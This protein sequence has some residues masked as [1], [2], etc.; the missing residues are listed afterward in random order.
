M[1]ARIS[2]A[3]LVRMAKGGAE[4]EVTEYH[5]DVQ[6]VRRR[7]HSDL[8]GPDGANR[9]RIIFEPTPASPI[10][11][12]SPITVQ[13][14]TGPP[15]RSVLHGRGFK[16]T[17]PMPEDYLIPAMHMVFACEEKDKP[18]LMTT[19]GVPHSVEFG[20]EPE[21]LNGFANFFNRHAGADSTQPDRMAELPDYDIW[22]VGVAFGG[23]Q[24]YKLAME[25]PESKGI[26]PVQIA[27]ACDI[28]C[29]TRHLHDAQPGDILEWKP[30]D[31]HLR[32][33]DHTPKFAPPILVKHVPRAG[34]DGGGGGGGG[35]GRLRREVDYL[36]D[37]LARCQ[38]D[39]ANARTVADTLQSALAEIAARTMPE[40]ITPRALGTLRGVAPEFAPSVMYHLHGGDRPDGFFN[41]YHHGG[42]HDAD[43]NVVDYDIRDLA[44]VAHGRGEGNEVLRRIRAGIAA[45][46][47]QRAA[48]NRAT[49]RA[50]EPFYGNDL[51]SYVTHVWDWGRHDHEQLVAADQRYQRLHQDFLRADDAL[52][53]LATDYNR[54]HGD[55]RMARDAAAAQQQVSANL[56][57]R[58]A[59]LVEDAT[60]QLAKANA[61]T[62]ERDRAADRVAELQAELERVQEDA[63]ARGPGTRGDDD[64]E[65]ADGGAAAAAAA[66]ADDTSSDLALDLE[67]D[68]Y[69]AQ[70]QLDAAK[71]S[72]RGAAAAAK[73]AAE[74]AAN[75]LIESGARRVREVQ[76]KV[77]EAKAANDKRLEEIVGLTREIERLQSAAAAAVAGRPGAAPEDTRIAE[78]KA[79]ITALDTEIATHTANIEKLT[80]ASAEAETAAATLKAK[81]KQASDEVKAKNDAIAVLEEK[82][83]TAA[84]KAAEQQ[85]TINK[86]STQISDALGRRAAAAAAAAADGPDGPDGPVL[87]RLQKT[88]K[89]HTNIAPDAFIRA[90]EDI[91]REVISAQIADAEQQVQKATADLRKELTATAA[92]ATEEANE[93]RKKLI[94]AKEAADAELLAKTEELTKI[95]TDHAAEKR[96]VGAEIAALI[97]AIEADTEAG[98]FVELDALYT[99]IRRDAR[100]HERG[101]AVVK[102]KSRWHLGGDDG[103]GAAD[104]GTGV[105]TTPPYI[106][107]LMHVYQLCRLQEPASLK[108]RPRRVELDGNHKIPA[109]DVNHVLHS[110]YTYF[111]PI[112]ANL[113]NRPRPVT[114]LSAANTTALGGPGDCYLSP[115]EQT[116]FAYDTV[117]SI[118][119]LASFFMR[120]YAAGGGADTS[121]QDD[122]QEVPILMRQAIEDALTCHERSSSTRST[123]TLFEGNGK[124][125]V[126]ALFL[127]PVAKVGPEFLG[128]STQPRNNRMLD[129]ITNATSAGSIMAQLATYK[130][131]KQRFHNFCKNDVLPPRD[132]TENV[133]RFIGGRFSL[134]DAARLDNRLELRILLP[135]DTPALE[136]INAETDAD[137]AENEARM[138]AFL[139]VADQAMSDAIFD[140]LHLVGIAQVD[141]Y[142]HTTGARPVVPKPTDVM[143]TKWLGTWN[144]YVAEQRATDTANADMLHVSYDAKTRLFRWTNLTHTI[145][146]NSYSADLNFTGDNAFYRGFGDDGGYGASESARRDPASEE[147]ARFRSY[148][149]ATGVEKDSDFPTNMARNKVVRRSYVGYAMKRD[150][151]LAGHETEQ[152]GLLFAALDYS[153]ERTAQG[154]DEQ[155]FLSRTQNLS[156]GA[157]EYAAQAFTAMNQMC[158]DNKRR[159][160]VAAGLKDRMAKYTDDATEAAA[161]GDL[162]DVMADELGYVSDI[163][164]ASVAEF[165]EEHKPMLP[166]IEGAKMPVYCV[167]HALSLLFFG[168]HSGAE[169]GWGA[170]A[171]DTSR[172]ETV[173][174]ALEGDRSIA[175]VGPSANWATS[176]I[177]M[178]RPK[179]TLV[180]L[181]NMS[182][183]DASEL[184]AGVVLLSRGF[185]TGFVT[186][187]ATP[188]SPAAASTPAVQQKIDFSVEDGPGSPL[189]KVLKRRGLR[190]GGRDRSPFAPAAG[191][192][193]DIESAARF[194]GRPGLLGS[195]GN[196][197]GAR[198]GHR[199]AQPSSTNVQHFETHRSYNDMRA[200]ALEKI[201]HHV[202]TPS[203]IAARRT[204]KMH[205]ET[206]LAVS[207]KAL[208]K[209]LAA[210]NLTHSLLT[211]GVKFLGGDGGK[212]RATNVMDLNYSKGSSFIHLLAN[213]VGDTNMIATAH[214]PWPA[215][216]DR[217]R[218]IGKLVSKSHNSVR[219]YLSTALSVQ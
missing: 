179:G 35:D 12:A 111:G 80:T 113:A 148:E 165:Y 45:A 160:V 219:V 218:C 112:A 208:V 211:T 119:E 128:V 69:E 107:N 124:W 71:A 90:V 32:W 68:L 188:G 59:A 114:V 27:G 205:A 162:T 75:A 62:E 184:I 132:F 197:R 106:V 74:V 161:V 57:A 49:G 42:F 81:L 189:N 194:G 83:A 47:A 30:Q 44:R 87:R 139:A 63:R 53:H 182:V 153:T 123:R 14:R 88:F 102:A 67:I 36:R 130:G 158:L 16:A 54:I 204:V 150:H 17:P 95:E 215:A 92:T 28:F 5:S 85:A 133:Q 172:I 103:G 25:Y 141:D 22:F 10:G 55:L 120:D 121:F 73:E 173:I 60:D 1:A 11:Q 164:S 137:R 79:K 65:P 187:P 116:K 185:N 15:R 170:D 140:L 2:V 52:G 125:A 46:R 91:V 72:A 110:F 142:A 23:L 105:D 157:K 50:P 86:Y 8:K 64:V 175:H 143:I 104:D 7:T 37:Q 201:E 145:G 191:P 117:E 195:L 168:R 40:R 96:V 76:E 134:S 24:D 217:S 58:V 97:D 167:D 33:S 66:P 115:K 89:E 209:S 100:A 159:T 177:A 3:D 20:G 131:E 214:A 6:R 213:T 203:Q 26:F 38:D 34:G 136:L 122:S 176:T 108:G 193:K 31:S 18:R 169:F 51:D 19:S 61:A 4:E 13:M 78:L 98:M 56:Q 196:R 77:D 70:K 126:N 39:G 156:F 155:P 9:W 93:H 174:K 99:R 180:G 144:K 171:P 200:N 154:G 138:N 166:G 152:I 178:C 146:N 82:A 163:F 186:V 216:D 206:Q 94:G 84:A 109:D 212:T 29:D 118:T 198:A 210:A 151:D 183:A 41:N 149:M 129:M 181:V 207:H 192:A 21:V 202:F 101:Y 43:G 127:P 135:E 147:E 190:S 48:H 199:A